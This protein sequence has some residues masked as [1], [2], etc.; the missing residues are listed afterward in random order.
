MFSADVVP[1]THLDGA[2]DRLAFRRAAGDI[3]KIDII[4]IN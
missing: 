2:I 3:E 1:T 4:K